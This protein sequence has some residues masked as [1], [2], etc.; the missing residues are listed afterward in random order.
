VLS[1]ARSQ[2]A[3][4]VEPEESLR[5][6]QALPKVDLHVHLTG[7]LRASTVAQLSGVKDAARLL[8][9]PDPLPRYRDFFAP[10]DG[11]L[12]LVPETPANV[13]R[14]LVE[15]AEDFAADNVRYAELR[16]SARRPLQGGYFGEWMEAITAAVHDAHAAYG[17]HAGVI[18]GFARQR[19]TSRTESEVMWSRML[20]EIGTHPVVVGLDVWGDE[21][22]APLA[23]PDPLL[24]AG[25]RRGYNLTMH[26][27]E[28]GDARRLV[29]SALLRAQ[30]QRLSHGPVFVNSARLVSLLERK[31]ILT[32][33]CLTS[34]E[35]TR[36]ALDQRLG[37]Q[38]LR[39]LLV[40]R[41][42]FAIC[43][44][45][46]AIFGTTLSIEM[47]KALSGGLL[48]GRGL[49]RSLEN[50]IEYSFATPATK[51]NLRAELQSTRVATLI[52]EL[53]RLQARRTA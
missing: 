16:I 46:P 5:L 18:L 26:V 51:A 3:A 4:A 15:T 12:A 48:S 45:D 43:T 32:E 44:D 1:S 10:W 27:G 24:A 8:H 37:R 6:L 36:T 34:N 11:I 20:D 50:A 30:P 29:A 33:V 7:S 21:S 19:F 35:I 14:M 31:R 9:L 38:A 23:E 52:A 25:H 49:A 17:F 28:V 53:G 2:R 39:R 41:A 22:A 47:S 13:Y 42:P 40:S